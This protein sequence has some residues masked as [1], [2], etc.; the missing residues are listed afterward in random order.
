MKNNSAYS[1]YREI[2]G[3]IE[4]WNSCNVLFTS[5]WVLCAHTRQTCLRDLLTDN[6]DDDDN[7]D[8]IHR[9][10]FYSTYF[11]NVTIPMK[12]ILKSKEQLCMSQLYSL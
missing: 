12:Y 7:D 4:L 8:V 10:Q 11:T 5:S 6:E 1:L 2:Y 9:H 3:A